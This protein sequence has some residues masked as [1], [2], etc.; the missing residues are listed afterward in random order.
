MVI[1]YQCVMIIHFCANCMINLILFDYNFR[2]CAQNALLD[3]NA[4][5]RQ[6]LELRA[7]SDDG[8]SVTIQLLPLEYVFSSKEFLDRWPSILY[9]LSGKFAEFRNFAF[10]IL[11]RTVV[12]LEQHAQSQPRMSSF[13]ALLAHMLPKSVL[14]LFLSDIIVFQSLHHCII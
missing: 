3:G 14:S 4:L 12:R 13:G 6:R 9:D 8:Q 1:R 11:N 2:Q 5:S 7:Q 10:Q